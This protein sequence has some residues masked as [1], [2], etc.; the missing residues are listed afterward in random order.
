MK[1]K[2]SKLLL[3]F[4]IS[5]NAFGDAKLTGYV[6]AYPQYFTNTFVDDEIN[7][8]M[9]NLPLRASFFWDMSDFWGLEFSWQLIPMVGQSSVGLFNLLTTITFDYR[10]I[11][12]DPLLVKPNEN[13]DTKFILFNNPDRFFVS[14]SSDNFTMEVGRQIV[15]FGSSRFVNPTDVVTPFGLN[16]IDR[17]V[18]PGVDAVRLKYFWGDYNL[19]IG[20]LF[21]KDRLLKKSDVS[22]KESA[23]FVR[24]VGTA[25]G[26][27]FY[28]MYQRFKENN[29]FGVDFTGGLGGA[30]IWAEYSYVN[31]K[32]QDSID[33]SR[34]TVGGQYFFVGEWS[35]FGEY[36]YNGIGTNNQDEYLPLRFNVSHRDANLFLIGKH[37]LA[38]FGTHKFSALNDISLGGTWNLIDSSLLINGLFT[39]NNLENHYVDVGLFAGVG[40]EGGEFVRYLDSYYLAYRFYY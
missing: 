21:G 34:L 6:K 18:R 37:Y 33:Y 15:A 28:L 9:L 36:H 4:L 39:W 17:E 35:I 30:T 22:I 7:D 19:D 10:A 23:I 11:Y 1:I 12:T 20:M 3:I 26:N 31:S 5:L 32:K 14:Y 8:F 25:G 40:A 24:A 27:D 29:L 2:F 16:T 13:S 38:L